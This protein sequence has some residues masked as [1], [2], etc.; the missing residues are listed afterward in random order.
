MQFK[1]RFRRLE[2]HVQHSTD[3]TKKVGII[4]SEAENVFKTKRF[5]PIIGSLKPELCRHR[6]NYKLITVGYYYG[7]VTH[8]QI[9]TK[10]DYVA[11]SKH[12]FQEKEKEIE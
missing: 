12:I 1:H 4:F 3:L 9:Q 7:K 5:I 2:N 8:V 10:N 6:L 11:V